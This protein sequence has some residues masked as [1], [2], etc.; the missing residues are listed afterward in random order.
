MG[1]LRPHDHVSQ[2]A[3]YTHTLGSVSLENPDEYRGET[4]TGSSMVWENPQMRIPQGILTETGE[5]LWVTQVPHSRGGAT[6]S[7]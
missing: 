2:F 6:R 7:I 1:L 5:T 3:L 4:Q